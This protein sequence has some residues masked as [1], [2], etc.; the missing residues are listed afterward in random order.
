MLPL[1]A[2]ALAVLA[3]LTFNGYWNEYF[4]PLIFHR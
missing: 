1:V 2:P 3:I 4:R